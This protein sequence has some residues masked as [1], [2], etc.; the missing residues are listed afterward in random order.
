MTRSLGVNY[1][2]IVN[3]D[4]V[5]VLTNGLMLNGSM[6]QWQLLILLV[7]GVNHC[8]SM[9]PST[10]ARLKLAEGT[11]RIVTDGVPVFRWCIGTDSGLDGTEK[12][13]ER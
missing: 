5:T 8:A 4:S 13:F 7:F 12:R 2:L 3:S 11:F 1:W 10:S 6:A 9:L